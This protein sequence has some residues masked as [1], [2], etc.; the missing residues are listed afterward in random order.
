MGFVKGALDSRSLTQKFQNISS[1]CN[2]Y[3]KIEDDESEVTIYLQRKG[4]L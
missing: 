4:F 2:E 1:S 3:I